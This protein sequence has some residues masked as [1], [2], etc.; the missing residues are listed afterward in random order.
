MFARGDRGVYAVEHAEKDE[1]AD[2]ADEVA[3][4]D[5]FAVPPFKA[6]IADEREQQRGVGEVGQGIGERFRAMGK[7]LLEDG[8]EVGRVRLEQGHH[9]QK[10]EGQQEQKQRQIGDP[11]DGLDPFRADESA[12]QEKERERE[13]RGRGVVER[14]VDEFFEVQQRKYGG[15]QEID[16][17]TDI[18]DTREF[19]EFFVQ[20]SEQ[21]FFRACRGGEECD[22]HA[23]LQQEMRE[24]G[25]EQVALGVAGEK[26]RDFE[27]FIHGQHERREE[28]DLPRGDRIVFRKGHFFC[29]PLSRVLFGE[30]KI[31]G[32]LVRSC[33]PYFTTESRRS[34]L[35]SGEKGASGGVP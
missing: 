32:R 9:E 10:Y 13:Q 18:K 33:R 34:P 15:E 30:R 28:G 12:E 17:V 19:A 20:A 31:F 23:R 1:H 5:L 25:Q 2:R 22:E 16:G 29:S 14:R 4:D 11:T 8:Q 3:A 6:Q 27:K 24:R 35:I 26:G 7:I 21:R